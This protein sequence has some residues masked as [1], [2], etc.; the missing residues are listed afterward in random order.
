MLDLTPAHTDLDSIERLLRSLPE[1]RLRVRSTGSGPASGSPTRILMSELRELRGPLLGGETLHIQATDLHRYDAGFAEVGRRFLSRLE[2][3]IPELR[4]PMTRMTIGLFLSSGG[5]VAPFH[6][7][8]EHNFLSQVVGDKKMHMF[9]P[10]DLDIF[11]CVSRER[12]AFEDEH[13]LNTYRPELE[14]RAEIAHLVPG[15]TLYHPP[16]GPHWVD[17]GRDSYS[18]SITLSFITPSVDRTLLLHKLNRQ[19]RRLGLRPAPVGQRPRVDRA[20]LAFARMARGI[21]R[22]Q[23]GA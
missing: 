3:Q 4:A 1:E 20:K 19:I 14:A 18:L 5:A 7:D 12:L 22:L 8:Q 23:R 2:E 9:P 17:T 10:E 16:M 21:A 13:M 6:A 11:P 15:T